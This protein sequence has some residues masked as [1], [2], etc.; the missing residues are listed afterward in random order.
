MPFRTNFGYHIIKVI[1]KRPSRGQL[2]V[3]QILISTPK[4]TGEIGLGNAKLKL[5]SV[6]KELKNGAKF[7][8]LVIKYSDDK[9][10]KENKGELPV[11]GVGRMVAEFDEA[12]FAL[13]DIGEISKPVQTEYGFHIIK[14]LEKIGVKPFDSMRKEIKSKVDNDARAQQARD[15]YFEKV[16]ATN[17]FKDYPKVWTTLVPQINQIPDTGA[18][19]GIMTPEMFEEGSKATMFSL[20]NKNYTQEDFISF[21]GTLTRGKINA[22]GPKENVFRE[23]YAMFQNKVVTDFQEHKLIDENPEFKSL[24]QEYKDGIMLFELMDRNVWGKASKDTVGLKNFYETQKD[25]YLWEPGFKGSVYTFKD[26]ESVKNGLKL[27]SK[28]GMTNEELV[29]SLNTEAKRDAVSVQV[30]RYEF[31]KFTEL[32]QSKI[33]EGKPS[34]KV[35]KSDNSYIVVLAEKVFT[36]K[37]T[38]SFEDARGYIISGYQDKLEKDWNSELRSIYPVKVNEETLKKIVK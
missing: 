17:G 20:D 12:A 34:E 14:L 4:S 2:K 18:V 7:E 6:Q 23:L 16:K 9:F 10:S 24:M 13:K 32:P 31:S 8:D 22:Q 38:K 26:E 21:A 37:E 28:K 19:A 29:K 3:A 15:L 5:D 27:L 30:G 25:K 36:Q 35:K 1:D 33:A 11:F